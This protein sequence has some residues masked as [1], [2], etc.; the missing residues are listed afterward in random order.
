MWHQ[1]YCASEPP[2]GRLGFCARNGFSKLLRD[3]AGILLIRL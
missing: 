1:G 3:P 2:A